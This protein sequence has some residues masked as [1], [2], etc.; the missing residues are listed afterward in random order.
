MAMSYEKR[1]ARGPDIKDSLL[2]SGLLGSSFV[3]RYASNNKSTHSEEPVPKAESVT[4]G[5]QKSPI[6]LRTDD[7]I[8]LT[9]CNPDLL[10]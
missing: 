10:F 3:E 9:I 8:I 5:T 7:S 4:V 2:S 6:K 1:I